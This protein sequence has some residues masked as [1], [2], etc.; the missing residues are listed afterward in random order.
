MVEQCSR[1]W[2]SRKT[3]RTIADTHINVIIFFSSSSFSARHFVMISINQSE[4]DFSWAT[5]HI[6]ML[7]ASNFIFVLQNALRSLNFQSISCAS[8]HR[9]CAR[10]SVYLFGS[11]LPFVSVKI[12]GTSSVEQLGFLVWWNKWLGNLLNDFTTLLKF[13]VCWFQMCYDLNTFERS[14]RVN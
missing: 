4:T 13:N 14:A 11:N 12:A 2:M 1:I 5:P 8:A 10:G 6:D 7:T 9:P 3:A